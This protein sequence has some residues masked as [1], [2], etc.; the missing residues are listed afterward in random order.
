MT[1]EAGEHFRRTLLGAG[2]LGRRDGVLPHVPR[3]RPRPGAPAEAHRRRVALRPQLPVIERSRCHA[4]LAPART[5]RG[6]GSRSSSGARCR[7]HSGSLG[8]GPSS[9]TPSHGSRH[10]LGTVISGSPDAGTQVAPSRQTMSWRSDPTS[11]V[12]VQN[13]ACTSPAVPDR[14]DRGR[15]PTAAAPARA[16][17]RPRGRR[18]P[19]AADRHDLRAADVDRAGSGRLG[20]ERLDERAH[21][22]GHRDR[23]DPR[24]AATTGSAGRRAAS[25]AGGSPRRTSSRRR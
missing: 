1:R 21:R 17:G 14:D 7:V 19:A 23:L 6:A 2:R 10:R 9:P 11:A 5:D 22:I 4:R 25:R 13:G 15:E 3:R 18:P 16:A 24:A 12:T 8:S 20:G